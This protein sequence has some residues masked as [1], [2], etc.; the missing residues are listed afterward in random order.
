MHQ[1]GQISII[2]PFLQID[3]ELGCQVF[4]LNGAIYE[5]CQER[6]DKLDTFY[7]LPKKKKK[8]TRS[9]INTISSQKC[10][11]S[12]P[13]RIL[14]VK[15][16]WTIEFRTWQFWSCSLLCIL[17]CDHSLKV[18]SSKFGVCSFNCHG[19][20]WALLIILSNLALLNFIY[21]GILDCNM[22]MAQGFSQLRSNKPMI[23]NFLF[24]WKCIM[25]WFKSLLTYSICFFK[26]KQVTH[27]F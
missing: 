23:D 16:I 6:K 15:L 18:V 8:L 2:H 1:K 19:I 10:A 7:S 14:L 4:Y 17:D 5:R 11:T 3:Q 26:E 25:K 27:L 12:N 13:R 20:L 24:P 22:C 21:L 9:K